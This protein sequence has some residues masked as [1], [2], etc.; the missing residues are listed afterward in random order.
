[1]PRTARENINAS[2]IHVITQGIK[3]EYIFR[4]D[5][6][7]E[8]YIKLLQRMF[9]EF[10][11]LCLLC[12]CIMDNHAHLLMYTE[13]VTEVSKLMSRVNTTYGIYYN[14]HEDRV[15]YVFR[16]R[17][18]SQAI[19]DEK[20]LYNTVAYIHRNPVKA[21]MVKEMGEYK[22]SSYQK[23]KN[24]DMQKKSLDLLFN[25]NNYLEK[26]NWIHKNFVE[27]SIL[28]VQEKNVSNEEIEKFIKSF[29]SDYHIQVNEIGKNNYFLKLFVNQLKDEYLV[30]DKR[31][32][33]I[34]G[35]G[36]NRITNMKK[37]L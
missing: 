17:Y 20:H 29:C 27:D 24:G 22:Y 4:K 25:T 15:G 9:Q 30:T 34:L 1:M 2:Y 16:N 32:T 13:D 8:E 26:F 6:Y 31:I 35:I 19:M 36:K 21:N 14:K 3:K 28:E 11:Q 10:E 18:Y 23:M 7:K 12:Y 5:A 33:E 37:V